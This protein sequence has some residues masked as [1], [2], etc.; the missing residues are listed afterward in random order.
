MAWEGNMARKAPPQSGAFAICAV[1]TQGLE[2][3]SNNAMSA[4]LESAIRYLEHHGR[5][6]KETAGMLDEAL[7]DLNA[8]LTS[9]YLDE[10]IVPVVNGLTMT[11]L[12]PAVH[13]D[14]INAFGLRW[15][16][17]AVGNQ[18]AL[19]VRVEKW[20]TLRFLDGERAGEVED[21]LSWEW[22]PLIPLPGE[23]VAPERAVLRARLWVVDHAEALLTSLCDEALRI[24]REAEL[25]AARLAEIM[26]R[27]AP[28]AGTVFP[29]SQCVTLMSRKQV[30]LNERETY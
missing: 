15:F 1:A 30:P 3:A 28:P 21:V 29:R 11:E 17:T 10:V 19:A 2:L 22:Q 12:A 9:E 5:H 6:L 16:N 20:S 26:I 7:L 25:A 24:D 4:N 8:G 23:G 14:T 27:E 18:L 13:S